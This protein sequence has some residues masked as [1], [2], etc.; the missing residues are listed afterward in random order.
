MDK[1]VL[2]HVVYRQTYLLKVASGSLFV[3]ALDIRNFLK[4]VSPAAVFKDQVELAFVLKNFVEQQ[5]ARMLD[6]L[7]SGDFICKEICVWHCRLP[8]YFSGSE[9]V[10]GSVFDQSYYWALSYSELLQQLVVFF[11]I[12]P[13]AEDLSF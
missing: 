2:V 6:D 11:D 12:P 9:L 1:V 5:N 4:Q 10:F 13:I 7:Q 8:N 3:N